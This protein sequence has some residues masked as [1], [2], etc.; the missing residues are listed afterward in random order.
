MKLNLLVLRVAD[1]AK[2]RA[3]YEALGLQLVE[4]RHGSGPDHLSARL[5]GSVLELYPASQASPATEVLRFGLMIN[6][7]AR[8]VDQAVLAGGVL[9]TPPGDTAWGKRA[10]IAAPDGHKIELT[11]AGDR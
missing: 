7:L 9:V 10:V 3:F 11:E 5:E 6:D 2:S 1:V 4:E 8:T